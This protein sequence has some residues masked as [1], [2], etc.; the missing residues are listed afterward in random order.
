M[1]FCIPLSLTGVWV[2]R[3]SRAAA[4]AE[5]HWYSAQDDDDEVLAA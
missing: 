2:L 4:A 3:Q 1:F 5:V